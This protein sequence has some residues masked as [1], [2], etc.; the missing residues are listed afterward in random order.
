V[1]GKG[2]KELST[3]QKKNGVFLMKHLQRQGTRASARGERK[4]RKRHLPEGLRKSYS[5]L[6]F[7]IGFLILAH[8][9]EKKFVPSFGRKKKSPLATFP[10]REK[11]EKGEEKGRDL[12]ARGGKTNLQ[13]KKGKGKLYPHSGRKETV[14][15]KLRLV[16]KGGRGDSC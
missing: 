10:L 12:R 15:Y 6:P 3:S 14:F 4:K 9:G 2:K 11:R 1:G 7:K 16:I 13:G 5:P 8:Q